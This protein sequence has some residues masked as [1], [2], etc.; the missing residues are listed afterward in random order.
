LS[1]FHTKYETTVET[2]KQENHV[3][4]MS[5]L[6]QKTEPMQRQAKAKEPQELSPA[7]PLVEF[8]EPSPPPGLIPSGQ[9]LEQM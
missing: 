7:Q 8:V 6:L 2:T 1:R 4:S 5:E 3:V 9:K